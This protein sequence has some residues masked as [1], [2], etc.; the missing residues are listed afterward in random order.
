MTSGLIARMPV[1][2]LRRV[3]DPHYAHGPGRVQAFLDDSR[4]QRILADDGNP[5]IPAQRSSLGFMDA[6][7]PV[8]GQG[9]IFARDSPRAAGGRLFSI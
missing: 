1:E 4:A 9:M 6:F 8:A 3:V 2:Q 7:L 5:Q